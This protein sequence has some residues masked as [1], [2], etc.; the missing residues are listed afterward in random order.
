MQHI[1]RICGGLQTELGKRLNEIQ[2]QRISQEV[3][4][5]Q[6]SDQS[7]VLRVGVFNINNFILSKFL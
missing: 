3:E 1:L 4:N 6:W 2:R 7:S 5:Q